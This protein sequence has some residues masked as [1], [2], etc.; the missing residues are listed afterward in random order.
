MGVATYHH[1]EIR[2]EVVNNRKEVSLA[3]LLSEHRSVLVGELEVRL[4]KVT[5]ENLWTAFTVDIQ[6]DRQMRDLA[7]STKALGHLISDLIDRTEDGSFLCGVRMERGTKVGV[8]RYIVIFEETVEAEDRNLSRN[9]TSGGAGRAQ[10]AV[11]ILR[12][13]QLQRRAQEA[14]HTT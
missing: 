1:P 12:Q 7:G 8:Q 13:R 11:D 9:G 4:D 5:A 3:Y 10:E 14:N 2:T 6:A